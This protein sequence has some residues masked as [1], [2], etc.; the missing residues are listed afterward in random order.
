MTEPT[1]TDAG[2][3]KAAGGTHNEREGASPINAPG[4]TVNH[5]EEPTPVTSGGSGEKSE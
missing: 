4:G 1:S 5:T 2:S 3:T